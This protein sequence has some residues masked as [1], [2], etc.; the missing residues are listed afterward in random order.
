MKYKS[1]TEYGTGSNVD[2]DSIER[3]ITELVIRKIL[4]ENIVTNSMGF[5]SVYVEQGNSQSIMNGQKIYI[6]VKQRGEL[7]KST[8]KT[9]NVKIVDD[10]AQEEKK[11]ADE[12]FKSNAAKSPFFYSQRFGNEPQGNPSQNPLVTELHELLKQLSEKILKV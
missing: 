6:K 12:D 2:R 1:Y 8:R 11:E 3:L 4:Q 10:E 9:K 7:K 5:T